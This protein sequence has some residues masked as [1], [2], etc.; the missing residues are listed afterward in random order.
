MHEQNKY[1]S[2]VFISLIE[3]MN[4]HLIVRRVDDGVHRVDGPGLIDS[5][6]KRWNKFQERIRWIFFNQLFDILDIVCFV[7]DFV[8]S[9]FDQIFNHFTA[10]CSKILDSY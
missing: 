7:A 5:K 6:I 1:K 4:H 8:N 3:M 2:F 9:L 10:E